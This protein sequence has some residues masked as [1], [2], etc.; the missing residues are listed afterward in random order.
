MLKTILVALR[1]LLTLTILT[2]VIYPVV[3][4][5]AAQVLFPQQANGSLVADSGTVIGSSLIGQNMNNDP[6]Y[7][8]PRPSASDYDPLGAGGSNL[9]P[10]SATL[11]DR[12]QQRAADFIAAHGLPAGS[13][14][15]AEMLFASASG[16]D[17]HISPEAAR[18]Q[19][20]RV[21]E[22]R[23]LAREIVADLVEQHIEDPQLGFLGQAR[24]NV[25]ML[26][27]SLDAL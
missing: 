18:L 26:N 7:F 25:L 21:A 10:T 8:W 24:V 27:L 1:V 19:I 17:P 3:I 23:G 5:L 9:A 11:R 2:G 22:A 14:I 16:L 6:R 20:D 15:P 12:V 4:A 13:Q